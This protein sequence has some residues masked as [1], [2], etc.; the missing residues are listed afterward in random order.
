LSHSGLVEWWW[1]RRQAKAYRTF[2]ERFLGGWCR[3]RR[4]TSS[5][6]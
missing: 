4:R 6:V 1:G 2:V 3:S 5:S